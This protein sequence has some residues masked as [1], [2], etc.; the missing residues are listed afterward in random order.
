LLVQACLNGSRAPQ[1]HPAL[2]LTPQE[3][4]RDAQRVVAAGARALHVHPRNAQ[5][6]QSLEAQ[7]V[8]D[9]LLAIR[10]ACPGVPVGVSTALWIEPSVE[11]RLE[12]VR[13]WVV[14]PDYVSVNFSEPGVADLCAHFLSCGV[15]IEAGIWS[16]EDADLLLQLG[17]AER[18]LRILIEV[19]ERAPDAAVVAAEA[20]LERL[21][22]GHV[23]SPRRLLHG[24]TEPVAWPILELALQRGLDMR[25]GLEDTMTLPDG[26]QAADNAELVVA[27]FSKARQIGVLEWS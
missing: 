18:C 17:L 13:S 6:A 5:G 9:A 16:V 21:D 4:A 10:A 14:Q 7:D 23:R 2:P 11:R 27:A 20:V 8:A 3:L 22:A 25:I 12:R 26:R 19:Q 24:D 15:G 1:E